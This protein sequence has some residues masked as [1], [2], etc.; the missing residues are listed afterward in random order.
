MSIGC[1]QF[2]FMLCDFSLKELI[3]E[4]NI[5]GTFVQTAPVVGKGGKSPGSAITRVSYSQL[6]YHWGDDFEQLGSPLWASLFL[7][8]K[9]KSLIRT[10][11]RSFPTS[12]LLWFFI[13]FAWLLEPLLGSN[14]IHVSVWLAGFALQRRRYW[15]SRA[16]RL[17]CSTEWVASGLSCQS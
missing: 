13:I 4:C 17:R 12:L 14:T 5:R 1:F 6:L 8:I 11:L 15:P 10:F 9:R 16:Q 3:T 7:P 2:S